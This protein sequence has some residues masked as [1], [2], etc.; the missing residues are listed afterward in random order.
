MLSIERGFLFLFH[1]RHQEYQDF[2]SVDGRENSCSS[3]WCLL[4]SCLSISFFTLWLSWH[5][6]GITQ[7]EVKIGE[8]FP[9]LSSP[10]WHQNNRV[11]RMFSIA[12]SHRSNK[13]FRNTGS[14]RKILQ[15]SPTRSR[16]RYRTSIWK[17]LFSLLS[18]SL[19]QPRIHCT[20]EKYRLAA[21][22]MK[23]ND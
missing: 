16:L 12:V 2:F 21:F 14:R 8:S 6:K 1:D 4:Q 20:S 5:L 13:H 23:K 15:G 22:K 11:R 3:M 10:K 9:T 19:F 17:R 18:W 7:K